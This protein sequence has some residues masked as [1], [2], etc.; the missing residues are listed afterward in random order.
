MPKLLIY[1]RAKFTT[2]MLKQVFEAQA[3]ASSVFCI[4]GPGTTRGSPA[5]GADEQCWRCSAASVL[6]A[7]EDHGNLGSIRWL[8]ELQAAPALA[9]LTAAVVSSGTAPP[10]EE[11]S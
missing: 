6:R 10:R 4:P 3:V 9:A 7:S 2:H 11:L 8:G 1:S 5:D